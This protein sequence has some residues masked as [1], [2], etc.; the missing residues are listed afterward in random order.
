MLFLFCFVFCPQLFNTRSTATNSNCKQSYEFHQSVTSPCHTA[1]V[2]FSQK[3]DMH[4]LQ[5]NKQIILAQTPKI[6][7]KFIRKQQS[8]KLCICAWQKVH[9][10]ETA[11]IFHKWSVKK[12]KKND[13]LQKPCLIH[14]FKIYKTNIL[15]N[16]AG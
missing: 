16:V 3:V 14:F 10:F 2:L 13:K 12:K 9:F 7:S 11:L 15:K 1:D 5:Y 6:K 8:H 4:T